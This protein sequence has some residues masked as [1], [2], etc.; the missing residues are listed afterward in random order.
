MGRPLRL[1]LLLIGL[2]AIGITGLAHAD[3]DIPV[4]STYPISWQLDFVHGLPSRIVVDVPS[5]N[6]PQAYWYMTYTVTNNSDKEQTFLPQIE[7]LTDNG[8]VTKSDVNI[9]PQVFTAI[10]NREHNKLLEPITS[11]DGTIRLG[12]AEARD[13]VAIWPEPM[14]RMGHFS[15]FVTGLSG[16]AVIMKKIDGKY[17]KVD[18]AADMKEMKDLIILR[19]TLQLNF[20]IRGD[21]VYPGEDEVN[22]DTEEWIMR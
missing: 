19:K 14:P 22:K 11:I 16:E 20:F 7:M 3:P 8:T 21:E 9:P 13:G 12:E 1:A 17:T 15:I 2:I 6:V 5:M 4:P 18:Q 10:K